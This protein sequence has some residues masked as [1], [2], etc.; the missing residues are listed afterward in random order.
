MHAAFGAAGA[1]PAADLAPADVGAALGLS[2]VDA[3]D[4]NVPEAVAEYASDIYAYFKES[5]VSPRWR[6]A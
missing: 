2:E 5:E 4:I 1:A 6:M 3:A